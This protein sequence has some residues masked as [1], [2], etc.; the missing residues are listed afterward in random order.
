MEKAV[1]TIFKRMFRVYAHM[2]DKHFKQFMDLGAETHLNTCF[3]RFVYFLLEFSLV[4]EKELEPLKALIQRY[5]E[6]KSEKKIT[7]SS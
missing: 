4:D 2:Y 6:K 5:K 1:R 7:N 3:E